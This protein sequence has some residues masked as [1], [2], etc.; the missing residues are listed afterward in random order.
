VNGADSVGIVEVAVAQLK[1]RRNRSAPPGANG[2]IIVSSETLP[3]RLPVRPAL[4]IRESAP[5][6]SDFS[7]RSIV[8][9]AFLP[10]SGPAAYSSRTTLDLCVDALL[11]LRGAGVLREWSWLLLQLW[12]ASVQRGTSPAWRAL[13]SANRTRR[14]HLDPGA[15]R[16]VTSAT[17]AGLPSATPMHP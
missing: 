3:W 6:E 8:S 1:Q 14:C 9:R 13:S 16:A 4:A 12:L 2:A 10:I 5:D 7:S 17:E 11:H 15:S